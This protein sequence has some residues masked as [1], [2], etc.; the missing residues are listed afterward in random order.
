[1]EC[2]KTKI[3]CLKGKSTVDLL[4]LLEDLKISLREPSSLQ[5]FLYNNRVYDIAD[6]IL[7]QRIGKFFDDMSKKDISDLV[8]EKIIL[9]EVKDD[10]SR[11]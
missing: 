3:L 5:K 10:D 6:H 7:Y 9:N 8:F 2:L 4:L 1:M 11:T